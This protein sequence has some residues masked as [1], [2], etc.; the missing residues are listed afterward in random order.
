MDFAQK[1][2]HILFVDGFFFLSRTAR[3]HLEERGI[4]FFEWGF[5]SNQYCTSQSISNLLDPQIACNPACLML[6]RIPSASTNQES[7]AIRTLD[8]CTEAFIKIVQSLPE[9]R[10]LLSYDIPHSGYDF[11]VCCQTTSLDIPKYYFRSTGLISSAKTLHRANDW[12]DAKSRAPVDLRRFICPDFKSAHTSI[13]AIYLGNANR[14]ENTAYSKEKT[15]SIRMLLDSRKKRII[16]SI[17]SRLQALEYLAF[18]KRRYLDMAKADLNRISSDCIVYFLQREPEASTMPEA[19]PYQSQIEAISSLRRRLPDTIKLYVK[20]HPETF[21]DW[22]TISWPHIADTS[23]WRPRDYYLRILE[24]GASGLLTTEISSV[25]I[26]S[27][28]PFAVCT[29]TGSVYSEALSAG[30]P[31][32]CH[33]AASYSKW[34]GTVDIFCKDLYAEIQEASVLLREIKFDKSRSTAVAQE[35]AKSL[36]PVSLRIDQNAEET[37]DMEFE[38]IKTS[39]H[40]FFE[41]ISHL[42]CM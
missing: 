7:V 9:P 3:A 2:G 28:K 14:L 36:I 15:N 20:E 34:P 33:P 41:L 37:V 26:I 1:G 30:I 42:S 40:L 32:V 11:A 31:C 39:E 4:H 8:D 18:L 5:Y 17:D 10:L 29:L 23:F 16:Q 27:A 35:I 22:E 21:K 38:A 6:K 25:S 12:D 24:S 13:N 19:L